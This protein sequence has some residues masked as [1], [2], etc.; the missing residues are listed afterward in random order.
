MNPF[1]T[2][3][4]KRSQ[5][6]FMRKGTKSNPLAAYG[7]QKDCAKQLRGLRLANVSAPCGAG[8]TVALTLLAAQELHDTN[9]KQKQIIIAPQ[10][11]IGEAFTDARPIDVDGVEYAWNPQINNFVNFK[12]KS[13][14]RNLQNW[15]LSS[16]EVLLSDVIDR[17]NLNETVAVTSHQA[18]A[19]V[20][21]KLS[22]Y[23]RKQALKNLTITV[24]EAH[25][26]AGVF[27][28]NGTAKLTQEEEEESNHLGLVIQDAV[29]AGADTHVRLATATFYRGDAQPILDKTITAEFAKGTYILSWINHW[30]NL[31]LDSFRIDYHFY[32][33]EPVAA[34]LKLIADD[35]NHVFMIFVPACSL[36]WRK[37]NRGVQRFNALMDGLRKQ[38]GE[39]AVLDLVTQGTSQDHSVRRMRADVANIKAGNKPTFRCLVSCGIGLEGMDYVPVDRLINLGVQ[40]SIVR[41]VQVMGRPMRKFEGKR[42][43]T[44]TNYVPQPCR[45]KKGVSIPDALADRTNAILVCLAWDDITH[46]IIVHLI[47]LSAR[48]KTKRNTK[49]TALTEALGSQYGDILEKVLVAVEKLQD[50]TKISE[51]IAAVL[52][53]AEIESDPALVEGLEVAV[54]RAQLKAHDNPRAQLLSNLFDVSMLRKNGFNILKQY[55]LDEQTIFFGDC[56][57]VELQQARD[58]IRSLEGLEDF[59]IFKREYLK[60]YATAA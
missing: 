28:E 23:E 7:W 40:N 54:R 17:R 19:I 24:D 31:G 11:V 37:G 16:P 59:E 60:Y 15:L 34:T 58:A 21:G 26:I 13:V 38:F 48:P 29:H 18:L 46:P 53:K 44:I 1:V 51:A 49:G 30:D 50:K 47:E 10:R 12:N 4:P 42:V 27:D 43:V 56:S 9:L 5:G 45:P 8:K 2:F 35:S 36:A 55:R 3:A 32:E 6:S 57:K 20:W 25:H 22:K 41:A 52:D 33:V 14:L 39:D